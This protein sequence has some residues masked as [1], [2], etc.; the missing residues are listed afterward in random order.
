MMPGPSGEEEVERHTTVD[1]TSLTSHRLRKSTRQVL[2]TSTHA[3]RDETVKEG[4]EEAEEDGFVEVLKDGK[5]VRLTKPTENRV[6]S[7][8]YQD[9]EQDQDW[10]QEQ[11]D[12]DQ[13]YMQETQETTKH[14]DQE[15][16]Y[17]RRESES[18][19]EWTSRLL[20]PH[21]SDDEGDYEETTSQE[22]MGSNSTHDTGNYRRCGNC[23]HVG[24]QGRR[25][26]ES[27]ESTTVVECNQGELEVTGESTTLVDCDL[28]KVKEAVEAT[29]LVTGNQEETVGSQTLVDPVKEIKEKRC[30]ETVGS[31]TVDPVRDFKGEVLQ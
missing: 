4:E 22:D 14:Q 1:F 20:A 17:R 30:E 10:D 7:L 2:P 8:T 6:M 3:C 15:A 11:D 9:Q 29:T 28:R 26:E 19:E 18:H 23:N 31:Q 16:R 12:C 5:R 24:K 27:V 21:P 13:D 25:S